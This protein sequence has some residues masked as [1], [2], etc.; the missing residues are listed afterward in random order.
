[1]PKSTKTPRKP[2]LGSA[3]PRSPFAP[4]SRIPKDLLRGPEV[5]GVKPMPLPG[6]SRGR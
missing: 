2:G 3:V 6:K 4:Q 1:M 5:R